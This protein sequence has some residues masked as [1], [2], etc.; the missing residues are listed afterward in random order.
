MT[1]HTDPERPSWLQ[2]AEAAADNRLAS[3][4]MPA[5]RLALLMSREQVAQLI[6]DTVVWAYG[7]GHADARHSSRRRSG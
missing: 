7:R 6:R 4:Q 2:A 5:D 1:K 3:I